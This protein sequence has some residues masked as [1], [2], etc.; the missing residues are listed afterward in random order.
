MHCSLMKRI[1]VIGCPGSGKSTFSR[2]LHQLT[3]L[4]LYHLDLLYWNADKTTVDR[5]EFLKRLHDVLQKDAWIVDGNY[6]S[7]LEMRLAACD[8]VFFLDYPVEVCLEGIQLRKGKIRTDMPWIETEDD[9][10]FIDFIRSFNAQVRPE[11]LK[12][13]QKY[14]DKKIYVF[15]SRDEANHF[16]EDKTLDI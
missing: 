12:I 3:D 9:K 16:L 6:A 8:T 4:P 15:K 10:E 1:I 2:T 14:S 7:S 11:L 5:T 13:L